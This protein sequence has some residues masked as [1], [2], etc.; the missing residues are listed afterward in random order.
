MSD[1]CGNRASYKATGF[2]LSVRD[3]EQLPQVFVLECLESPLRIRK[4]DPR[5]TFV[6]QG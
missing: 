5:F 3:Q 1:D 6:K 2:E 4:Q